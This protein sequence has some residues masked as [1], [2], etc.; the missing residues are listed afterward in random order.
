MAHLGME[1]VPLW[2]CGVDAIQKV[3]SNN[4]AKVLQLQMRQKWIN[5]CNNWCPVLTVA[6]ISS[7]PWKKL[8]A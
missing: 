3:V 5:F 7:D 6:F 4:L 1:H 2:L 8:L